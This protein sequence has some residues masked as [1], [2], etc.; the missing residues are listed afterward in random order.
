MPG[1]EKSESG[2]RQLTSAWNISKVPTAKD[3]LNRST[4]SLVSILYCTMLICNS[5]K[6]LNFLIENDRF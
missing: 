3:C 4:I 5:V 2:G 6:V 1:E